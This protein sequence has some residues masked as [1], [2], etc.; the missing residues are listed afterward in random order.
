MNCKLIFTDTKF[1]LPKSAEKRRYK[2][3]NNSIDSP[4]YVRFLM[5]AI[6]P[7]T[8]HLTTKMHGLDF[9]C[10]AIPTVKELFVS[11]GYGCDNYDPLFFPE[12]PNKKYDFIIATECFEHFFFPAKDLQLINSKLH[13]NGIL[14][15]M[16]EQWVSAAKFKSWYYAKDATHVSFYHKSS[17]DF[18]ARKFDYEK[19]YSD[20]ARVTIFRKAKPELNTDSD[21]EIRENIA[22][23]EV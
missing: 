1:H 5:Q 16:T 18:I 2:F 19:I 6:A 13:P 11:Q 9:G 21:Q 12:L 8:E 14:I 20:N 3:H 15:I 23:E 22:H 10:G 17:M 7:A 4:G